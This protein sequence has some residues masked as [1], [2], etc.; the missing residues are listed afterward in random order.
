MIAAIARRLAADI[1]LSAGKICVT[2]GLGLSD[3]AWF[4]GLCKPLRPVRKRGVQA[5][6]AVWGERARAGAAVKASSA[7]RN[8]AIVPETREFCWDA[9][10]TV[11]RVHSHGLRAISAMQPLQRN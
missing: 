1:G 5:A 2:V 8:V 3:K 4:V 7:R 11:V 9:G 6:G 10:S